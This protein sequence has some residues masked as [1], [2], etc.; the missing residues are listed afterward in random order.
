[1][2]KIFLF[3]VCIR[4]HDKCVLGATRTRGLLLRRQPL[5]PPELREHEMMGCERHYNHSFFSE[6]AEFATAVE[7][8]INISIMI[9]TKLPEEKT[10]A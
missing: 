1:M 7:G 6:G 2:Q 10:C 4:Q 3:I 8:L 5:Y 9:F